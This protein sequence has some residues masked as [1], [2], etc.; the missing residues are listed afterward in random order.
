MAFSREDVIRIVMM[1]WIVFVEEKEQILSKRHKKSF[2]SKKG[3]AKPST[4]LT[5]Q[6]IPSDRLV[7]W[8][9]GL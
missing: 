7:Y 5:K 3:Y 1:K 2:P 6:R 4:F 8:F 9:G